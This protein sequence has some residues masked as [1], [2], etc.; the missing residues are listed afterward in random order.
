MNR[1][2]G[3]LPRRHE[4]FIV[5]TRVFILKAKEKSYYWE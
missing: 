2:R 4:E 3:I 1:H 5:I